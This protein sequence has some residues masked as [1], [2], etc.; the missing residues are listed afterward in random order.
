[1]G[2]KK[3]TIQYR[4]TP[5]LATDDSAGFS[6]HAAHFMSIDSYGTA[7]KRGAFKKTIRERAAKVVVLYQHY[8]DRP[9]GR[10]T[11]LKEDRD[12]LFFDATIV[13]STQYGAEAMALLRAEVPLGMSFGFETIKSRPVEESDEIDW[14]NAPEFY[15]SK[16]GR[17]YARVI[18]EVRI[19]EISLVTFPANE[20][21]T[22]T[23]V[24]SELE[25]DALSSLTEHMRAGTLNERQDA[26]IA[27]LVAAYRERKP[28]PA[29]VTP[30]APDNARHRN[31]NVT[32]ALALA[33]QRG[34]TGVSQ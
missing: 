19:W 34:W 15:T 12:G 20:Q 26:L 11:E 32:V 27:D 16:D 28:E 24:R 22:I 13:E 18:E 4:T 5:L 17:E 29:P 14:S 7:F 33:R 2:S 30:L 6:G 10:P 9:I 21:A 23:D 3:P 1:M 25:L 31:R 8:T